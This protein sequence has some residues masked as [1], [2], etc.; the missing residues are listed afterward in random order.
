M[1]EKSGWT[2]F[3]WI[4]LIPWV[5]LL[6]DTNYYFVHRVYHQV[7]ALFKF[8]HAEHHRARYPNVWTTYLTNPL[9]DVISHNLAVVALALLPVPISIEVFLIALFSAHVINVCGHAGIELLETPMKFSTPHG[10]IH[11][12]DKSG[13]ISSW[14][15]TVHYHDDHHYKVNVNYS[16]YFTFWD[17]LLGTAKFK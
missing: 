16:L 12:I 14:F 17:R 11:A 15:N 5:L 8:F 10:F 2:D 3:L 7:P 9:D 4:P 13:K 6:L 1:S